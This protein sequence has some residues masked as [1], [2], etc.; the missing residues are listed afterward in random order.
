MVTILGGDE[1]VRSE[2]TAVSRDFFPVFR[3]QPVLGR[4]FTADELTEG[5][6]PAAVVSEDFW[7][8]QLGG[9]PNLA[10]HRL[11]TGG[12]SYQVVGVMPAGFHFPGKTDIWIPES[13]A[14]AATAARNSH[15]WEAAIGR[16]HIGVSLA[17][18]QTEL[19]D[20]QGRIKAHYGTSVDAVGVNIQSLHDELVGSVTQPLLLLL[21]AAALV[22][23]IACVNLGSTLLARGTARQPELAM[24]SA[25]GAGRRRLVQ[26]LFTE[27]LLLAI[28]GAIAGLVVA[29]ILVR[30]L[31]ALAP[32]NLPRASEIRIDAWVLAFTVLISLV[33]ALVF[34]LL[35]A[36]RLARSDPGRVLT[37]GSRGN[38]SGGRGLQWNVLV[39]AEVA[40]ALV[41]LVG[42]GLL[43]RS[44]QKLLSVDPGF[45]SA[46]VLTM[47]LALPESTYPDDAAV[48]EF[49]RTLVPAFRTIPGV[50]DVGLTNILP[51]ESSFL[52]GRFEIEGRGPHSGYSYYR[53]ASAGYFRALG[54]PVIQGRLFDENDRAGGSDVAIVNQALADHYWPGEQATGKRIRNLANDSFRY[55]ADRWLTVVGVVGNVRQ[56]ALNGSIE[57][58]VYVDE[59]QRPFRARYASVVLRTS[60]P[61]TRVIATVRSRLHQLGP[62]VP[63]ELATLDARI[64]QSLA[65]RR[66]VMSVLGFF[67][68]VALL[69]AGVGI[70]GVVSYQVA[71]RTREIG[72]RLALGAGPNRV[73]AHVLRQGMMLVGIGL[74]AGVLAAIALTRV[75]SGL[76]Y[77]VSPSDPL[78]FGVTI[79][80]LT[81]VALLAIYIPARRA[82]RVD[83]LV[84]MQVE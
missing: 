9:D 20:I 82:T 1:P 67:A 4:T 71:Q 64:A 45:Q 54:I 44:F 3:L 27:S 30:A 11:R 70:Y 34:G 18:A 8:S 62:T 48:R 77:E 75:L 25:L 83:P 60:V 59:A 29:E 36:V 66:F 81:A 6:P 17:R 15:N 31:L 19:S 23:L 32:A 79:L 51:I 56:G 26:Q 12:T 74:I 73:L 63:A 57:P 52:S 10:A 68:E 58:I 24:R 16:L 28:L 33:T 55:G 65:G 84:A 61:P 72:V 39:G 78:T 42:A 5:G 21:G 2:A 38:T 69:L 53:V 37:S 41:L 7:R 50:R 43:I 35:P 49:Y 40:L 14:H 13:L 22:L 47:D 80:L 46:R 76:L